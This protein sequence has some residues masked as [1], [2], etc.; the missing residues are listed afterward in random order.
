[1]HVTRLINTDAYVGNKQED[2]QGILEFGNRAPW[3]RCVSGSFLIEVL[4]PFQNNDAINDV[5]F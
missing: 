2:V 3:A 5:I 1:M 4:Q